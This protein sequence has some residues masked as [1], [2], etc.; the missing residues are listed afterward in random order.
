MLTRREQSDSN[1]CYKIKMFK[2]DLDKLLPCFWCNTKM[3]YKEATVDHLVPKSHNGKDEE[4]NLVLCCKECNVSRGLVTNL[5][6]LRHASVQGCKKY[7]SKAQRYCLNFNNRLRN[8]RPK[9]LLWEN[10]HKKAG[11][12]F[13]LSELVELTVREVS[14][15]LA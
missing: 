2:A 10:R 15:G 4:T 9:I 3:S 7:P 5:L 13:S 6:L 11:L 1:A 14:I 8:L 12:E